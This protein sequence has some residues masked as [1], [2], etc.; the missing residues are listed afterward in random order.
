MGHPSNNV[1]LKYNDPEVTPALPCLPPR[2]R[3]MKTGQNQS[4]EIQNAETS[5]EEDMCQ[6][7]SLQNNEF[8]VVSCSGPSPRNQRAE[9]GAMSDCA[10]KTQQNTGEYGLVP[11]DT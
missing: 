11:P 7:P 1:I 2:K 4:C 10:N 3:N 9:T 8:K 6:S 5:K